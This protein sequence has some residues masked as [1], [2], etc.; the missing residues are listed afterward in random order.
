M[1][2]TL[3]IRLRETDSRRP[4]GSSGR[5]RRVAGTDADLPVA[6]LLHAVSD[7]T[8]ADSTAATG[9]DSAE[10]PER[11]PTTQ[12]LAELGLFRNGKIGV[13]VGLLFAVAVYVFFVVLPAE[14]N[15]SSTLFVLLAFALFVT[16]AILVTTIL[17]TITAIRRAREL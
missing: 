6:S 14:T 11:P 3:A 12:F 16:A 4:D 5:T 13:V 10:A 2:V 9:P 8:D 15:E 17:T 1:S 7:S